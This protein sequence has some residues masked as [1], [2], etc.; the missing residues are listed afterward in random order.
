MILKHCLSPVLALLGLALAAVPAR[1]QSAVD[2]AARRIATVSAIAVDEYAL[3]VVDGQVVSVAE[4]EEARLFL[5]EARRLAVQ[6]PGELRLAAVSRI[7]GLL[8]A[9]ERRGDA[10]V[11]SAHVDT[12]RTLLA[13]GLGI[14][15]DPLPSDPVALERGARLYASHC[16]ACHEIGRA[17][18]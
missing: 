13:S 11:L 4:L 17:H 1:A 9:V 8:A 18:V 3:G 5:A 2:A 7:E 6:L 15:L 14:R 12:L 16:A 10:S